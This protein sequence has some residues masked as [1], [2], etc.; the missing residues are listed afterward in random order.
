MEL[1]GEASL[2]DYQTLL[3]VIRF[4][5]YSNDL[6]DRILSLTVNDGTADSNTVTSTI[7]V[8][9]RAA[10][11]AHDWANAITIDPGGGTNVLSVYADGDIS[12]L[13][14]PTVTHVTTGNL[15]GDVGFDSITLSGAQLD[16]ILTGN[17]TIDLVTGTGAINLTSTSVDLNALGATDTSVA[18]VKFIS[19]STAA[20][21][22]V[23]DMHGQ[24][25]AF[26]ITSSGYADTLT[27]G[28]AADT[29]V[30]HADFGQ[31]TI[32]DYSA[33]TDYLSFDHTIFA[34]V[35]A[36]LA[37]TTDSGANTIIAFDG[38]TVTLNG[39]HKA[40]LQAHTDHIIVV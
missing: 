31:D 36:L 14:T 5:T 2:A 34:D 8:E 7:H 21:G 29:F 30:F 25:E 24:T 38:N 35:A 37:V 13:G 18:G 3:S 16:A 19:A 6:T 33:S 40:D 27:G 28:S 23:I 10:M 26:T 4:S 12:A 32:T 9:G 22:V 15:T 20:A 17:G 1:S 39:V 11:M